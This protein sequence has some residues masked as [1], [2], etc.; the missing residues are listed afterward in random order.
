M[1]LSDHRCC[2]GGVVD[3]EFVDDLARRVRAECRRDR[4]QTLCRP[5]GCTQVTAGLLE[6]S[7]QH[8]QRRDLAPLARG[9]CQPRRRQL[10]QPAAHL[11]SDVG[12]VGDPAILKPQRT[13]HSRSRNPPVAF[14]RRADQQ[15]Q[16]GPDEPRIGCR[17]RQVRAAPKPGWRRRHRD[18]APQLAI[19]LAD[20]GPG[21][22]QPSREPLVDRARGATACSVATPTAAVPRRPQR[23]PGRAAYR[24][25]CAWCHR[26]WRSGSLSS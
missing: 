11:T 24:H 4:T 23:P 5:L 25:P 12:R 9:R 17:R 6:A 18:G 8:A 2:R 19:G 26:R 16:R 14:E 1:V 22:R 21:V 13:H 10:A 3:V 15:V 20:Y 7:E